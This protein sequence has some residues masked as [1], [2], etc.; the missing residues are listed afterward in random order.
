MSTRTQPPQYRIIFNWDGDCLAYGE[1]PQSMEQIVDETFAPLEGTQVDAMFWS[2]GSHEALFPSDQHERAGAAGGRSYNS[3][4]AMRH[5]ENVW[6]LFEKGENPYQAMVERGHEL[7]MHVYV[8][9]R[10]NDNHFY[11]TRPHEFKKLN[12][13][14]KVRQ[15][16]P[17][18]LLDVDDVPEQRGVG[19]WNMANVG[20]R[21]HKLSYIRE[22]C[23]Q[24]D[25]D[26]VEIDWQRHPHHLPQH[27]AYRLRYTLTDLQRSLRQMADE[28]AEKKGRPFHVAVRVAT[29]LESCRRIGYDIPLWTKDGLCDLIIGAG[30]SAT[31]PGF[32]V[33][34][35]KRHTEGT[36]IRLYGGFDSTY[37]QEGARLITY[38]QWRDGFFSATAASYLDQ[39]GD[40]VY[41]FNWFPKKD[42]WSPLLKS[43]GTLETLKDNDKLYSVLRRGPTYLDGV[44]PNAVNDR[45]YGQTA[46]VLMPTLT[47]DGPT[48][49]ISIHDDVVAQAAKVSALQLHIEIAH[50]APEDEVGVSLD[51]EVLGPPAIID[52]AENDETPPRVSENKWLV[53]DLE[54]DQ[55]GKGQHTIKAVLI[56][57][58]RRISVPLTI[59][60]VDVHVRYR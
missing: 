6:S 19:S 15:D 58:D 43:M 48:F 27:D 36:G 42:D 5:D 44:K 56:N 16:H 39:G 12:K 7:G 33:S 21:E 18:W 47:G 10:M 52:V 34:E 32:E 38:T 54:P 60:H 37:R 28:I 40:G 57:R 49:T 20:V 45:I 4:R 24:A 22:A 51:G 8:S 1:H 3:V 9:M 55:L 14:T 25:W 53:W 2:I 13:G 17:E 46:T 50:W 30:G 59:D 26:G 23:A 29:T 35:F 31:D 41:C 11:N